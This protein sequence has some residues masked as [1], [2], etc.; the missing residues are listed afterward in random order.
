MTKQ[1]TCRSST[2]N[3]ARVLSSHSRDTLQRIDAQLSESSAA[4]ALARGKMF[5]LVGYFAEAA[6]SYTDALTLDSN[7]TEASARLALAQLKAEQREKALATAMSL[8]AC[9]PNFKF[10]ALASDEVVSAM[11]VLGDTLVGNNRLEDAKE[12]YQAA[13][14]ID[15]KDSYAAGRLAEL[16]LADKDH[17]K[18]LEL[19]NDFKNNPRFQNLNSL[20]ALSDTSAALLPRFSRESLAV[21]ITSVAVGRPLLVDGEVRFASVV[22][23]DDGWCAELDGR[24]DTK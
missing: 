18:A 13:R 20:L 11:T 17:K 5:E 9:N 15:S 14:K 6:E 21:R 3:H 24:A 23:G 19:R 22:E 2:L 8:A 16:H 7:L 4:G 1:Y 12:A 10:K